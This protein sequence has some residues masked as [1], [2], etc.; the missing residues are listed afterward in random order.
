[1]DLIIGP[2]NALVT[3]AKRQLFGQV[4]MIFWQGPSR[5]VVLADESAPANYGLI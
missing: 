5:L 2:G 4:G 1:V 3:E